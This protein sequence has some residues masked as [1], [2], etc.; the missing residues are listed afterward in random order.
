M[1][2]NI[3]GTG[4]L[5]C[6]GGTGM[7]H[8]R[9][10]RYF[11]LSL[12]RRWIGDLLYFAHQVPSVPVERIMNLQDVQA[13]R[14]YLG[15]SWPALFLKA[16]ALAAK[17]HPELRQ[18]YLRYP[19]ARGYEH[20]CSMASVAIER[21]YDGENAVFFGQIARPEE[22]S[23]EEIDQHLKDYKYEPIESFGIFRRLIRISKLPMLIRRFLWWISLN[24]SGGKRAKR[25]GTFGMS[26]YSSLG[27]S[28]LHPLSPLSYLLN[29]GVMD[30]RGRIAVRLVYDHRIVDGAVVARALATME[31][32]LT[33]KLLDELMTYEHVL[34]GNDHGARTDIWSGK[35]ND[36][37]TED[38][39]PERRD[40]SLVRR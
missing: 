4:R 33:G 28:S 22:H 3:H 14:Q 25:L 26:V 1:G 38:V 11:R 39:A 20:P 29:Y 12:P 19:W 32:L 8:H 5:H 21:K 24:W 2:N 17:Q 40:E 27:A 15:I 30:E 35:D 34:I 13:T 18:A 10:G 16:F 37:W 23:L 9:R 31:S 7:S 6:L 36:E